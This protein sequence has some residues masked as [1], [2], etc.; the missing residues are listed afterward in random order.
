MSD[1]LARARSLVEATNVAKEYF[2]SDVIR[3]VTNML[4]ALEESYKAD[5]A[6]VNP[7]G[8]VALQSKLKQTQAIRKVLSKEMPLPKI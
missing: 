4:E 1:D 3:A 5:L 7:E 8:L 2:G 6:D